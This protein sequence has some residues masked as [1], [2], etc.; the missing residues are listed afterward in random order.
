MENKSIKQKIQNTIDALKQISNYVCL[1]FDE[2]SEYKYI[3]YADTCASCAEELQ[4]LAD[5]L[6]VRNYGKH[7]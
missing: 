3:K 6:E 1:V 4:Q 7:K 2:E 5:Y